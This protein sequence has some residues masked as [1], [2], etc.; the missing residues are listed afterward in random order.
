T[1]R[2]AVVGAG[3]VGSYY[4]GRLW[5]GGGTTTSVLFHLRGENYDHCTKHGIDISS[6]H[7][8]FR[9]PSRDLLAYRTTEDM[10]RGILA[11]VTAGDDNDDEN[12][13]LLGTVG[14]GGGGMRILRLD[15]VRG[16]VHLRE[17]IPRRSVS[18]SYPL[19]EVPTLI[20]PLLSP[21]TRLLVIMNGLIED[22]LVSMMRHRRESRGLRGVGCRA[23]YGGMALICSNRISPGK[24]SHTYGGK[25]VCG[26][27]YSADAESG[28]VEG[29]GY[30]VDRDGDGWVDS[31]R[32]A[33][34]DLFRHASS[35][36][37]EFDP[38][39]RRGRWWKNVWNLPFSGISVSMGGIT[40]DRI[41]NDPSLRRLAYKVMDETIAIANA[42][43]RKHGCTED[44]LLGEE[45]K[46]EMM[47]LSDNM[48]PYKPSTMLD[49]HARKAM[50]VK[51]LFRKAVDRAN[52][53][54]VDCP[55]LETLVCQIEAH[56]RHHNLY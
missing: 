52:D 11:N 40:I 23:I 4:G 43:L 16:E 29:G 26:V 48:G 24:I 55:H 9:I 22:D 18:N 20:E 27:A 50:E 6:Y 21:Q 56:Q 53:L 51:Y 41:V 37:F 35:V 44:E 3:A 5:E 14:G 10:A 2:I 54:G 7:G 49:L 32:R 33:I 8:D 1:R 28:E 12:D 47:T 38:N 31:D 15:R 42:D 36:P 30:N 39:L 17:Y 46:D 25:L 34:E 19:D 45:T 13:D